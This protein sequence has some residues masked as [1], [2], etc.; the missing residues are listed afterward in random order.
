MT[1]RRFRVEGPFN[2]GSR[3]ALGARAERHAKVLRLGAGE[4]VVLFDGEGREADATLVSEGDALEALVERV[5]TQREP[6]HVVLVAGLPKAAV[7]EQLLRGVTEAGV[8]ELRL[9]VA[10]RSVAQ[11][12]ADRAAKKLERWRRIVEE[13][14]RQSERA[15]VPS[16]SL[17]D[18]LREALGPR[19]EGVVLLATDAREGADVREILAT[20]AEAY[21]LVVGPEGGLSPAE[22]SLV[23]AAGGALARAPL[24]VM[25][26]ETAAAVLTALAVLAASRPAA[27]HEGPHTR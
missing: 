13:A 12:D 3:V 14:A 27:G 18:G 10:E 4:A 22:L 15:R 2:E 26:V 6:W 23:T 19:P 25:R 5:R 7:L 11:A 9:F 8:S 1:E 16:L 24:P 17:H 21:V 20:R